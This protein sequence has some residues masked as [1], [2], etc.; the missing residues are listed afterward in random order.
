MS[1]EEMFTQLP[2]VTQAMLSD[3]IC[4]VQGGVSVQ[5]TL[6]QVIALGLSNSVLNST[7]NP[8]GLVAGILNQ[9]CWDMTN[10]ILYICTTTGSAS[11]A[12][13]M[14]TITLTA[15]AGISIVQNGANIQISAS[16]G[17]LTWNNVT[18]TSMQMI[19]DNGYVANNTS[20]VLLPLPLT[21]AFGDE[22]S[23]AGY[24][25]GGF[26][27][28]QS[29]GQQIICGANATTLGATGT[30]TSSRKGDAL[31]LICVVADTIWMYRN[32]PQGNLT[33]F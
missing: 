19:S 9:L 8:N 10:H 21:S 25:I 3:I 14:K 4:A 13:W 18:S 7:G 6:A 26:Q 28:T 29:A 15:G 30:L 11:T 20:Q 16:G 1:N 32:A 31:D 12:I 22:I 23:I 33:A 5:E 2:T 17:G 24:G 27:I